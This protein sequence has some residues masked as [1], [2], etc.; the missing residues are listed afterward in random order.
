MSLNSRDLIR[1]AALE[2]ASRIHRGE[3]ANDQMK[4]QTADEVVDDA[5]RFEH[6]INYGKR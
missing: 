4:H 2:A 1:I 3:A 5:E 6:Y